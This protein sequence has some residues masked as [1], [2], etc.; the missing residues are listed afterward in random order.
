ME[1]KDLGAM[2]ESGTDP[3]LD[4]QHS[5]LKIRHSPSPLAV[6]LLS[7]G[8]DSLTTAGVARRDGFDLALIH[9]NYGQ[10]TEEAELRAFSRIAAHLQVPKERQLVVHTN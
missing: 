6:V 10:R 7:G 4:I 1:P 9:F 8:M 3:S 5:E 2:S